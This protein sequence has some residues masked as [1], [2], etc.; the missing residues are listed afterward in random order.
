MVATFFFW[1]A[2]TK[3]FKRAMLCILLELQG[4]VASAPLCPPPP[5]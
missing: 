1:E 2:E 3:R 4:G 5:K